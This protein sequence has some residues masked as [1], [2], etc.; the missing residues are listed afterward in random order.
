MTSCVEPRF[1]PPRIGNPR[2]TLR[3]RRPGE[4][5]FVG[6]NLSYMSRTLGLVLIALSSSASATTYYVAPSGSDSAA[7]TSQA[8]FKTI[9]RATNLVNPGDTVIVRDGTYGDDDGNGV[10]A[11]VQRPGNASGWITFKSENPWGAKLR[12]TA[13]H[14]FFLEQPYIRI[15]GFD[16][17]VSHGTDACDAIAGYTSHVQV[18]GNHMHHIGNVCTD[19]AYGIDAVFFTNG[20]DW[21]IER[22]VIHDIGRLAPG[23]QGCVPGNNYYRNHDHGLY[24]VASDVIIRNNVFYDIKAGWAI[25]LYPSALTNVQILN[26]TFANPNPFNPGHIII[27]NALT[28]SRIANNI[29]YEPNSVALN[30]DLAG[31]QTGTLVQNNLVYPGAMSSTVPSG[32][33]MSGN[34]TGMT[35]SFVDANAFDF[36][37]QMTSPA[38]NAG[39]ATTLVTDDYDLVSRPQGPALDLGAFEYMTVIPP[40]TMAPSAP[41]SLVVQ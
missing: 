25:H 16:I 18:V 32:V 38:I 20:S 30:F 36:H 39:M 27:A 13:E 34:L 29:F 35:P 41:S 3:S 12:G 21:V 19:T 5:R 24:V 2:L 37:L 11:Y 15:E 9:Q 23:Q 4:Q 31:T 40:D 6:Y 8:P 33:M 14:G 7:G 26:N 22:N 10:I 17:S 28:N 1:S